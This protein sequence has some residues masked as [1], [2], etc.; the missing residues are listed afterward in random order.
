MTSP[1]SSEAIQFLSFSLPLVNCFSSYMMHLAVTMK[2]IY[3]S[4]TIIELAILFAL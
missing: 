2:A 4:F 3:I 1:L